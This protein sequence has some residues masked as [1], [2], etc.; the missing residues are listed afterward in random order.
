[1]VTTDWPHPA[2]DPAFYR[3][4]TLD[5]YRSDREALERL[6]LAAIIWSATIGQPDLVDRALADLTPDDFR[7]GA[8]RTVFDAILALHADRRPITA[9]E[10]LDALGDRLEL[11]GGMPTLLRILDLRYPGDHPAVY[12][13][14]LAEWARRERLLGYVRQLPGEVK[15]DTLDPDTVAAEITRHAPDRQHGIDRIRDLADDIDIEIASGGADEGVRLRWTSLAHHYRPAPGLMSVVTGIPGS[16]KSTLVDNVVVDLAERHG[17]R[18]A[19]FSPESAPTTRHVRRLAT[20]HLGCAPAAR[21][22]AQVREALAWLDR[23]VE[24]INSTDGVTVDEILRRADVIHRRDPLNGLVLDPWNEIDRESSR[25]SET[26]RISEAL[27]KIRRWSRRRSVHTWIV[28]HPTKLQ[29]QGDGYAP[30]TLYDVSGS[31]TWRDKADFGLVV[32]R[33]ATRPGPTDVHVVKVR[34]AAQG[35]IG[36]VRLS[37]DTASELFA[38]APFGQPL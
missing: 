28:A 17:W 33:D 1:M 38:D 22:V 36:K 35:R 10:L 37:F 24:W 25:D 4:P 8:L 7:H 26:L 32:H 21:P 5:D 29:R 2:E 14:L 12:A 9:A 15:A 13:G 11:I 34:F 20:M 18:F 30:P 31:A 23:H 3:D 19:V 6:T 27:T 16:G